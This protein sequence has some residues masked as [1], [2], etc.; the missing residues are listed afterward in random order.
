MKLGTLGSHFLI[1]LRLTQWGLETHFL[2]SYCG[3]GAQWCWKFL[4]EA[5]GWC[6][7]HLC[8][9]P[10]STAPLLLLCRIY[11]K[12]FLKNRH[13]KSSFPREFLNTGE[14]GSR[15]LTHFIQCPPKNVQFAANPAKGKI[16]LLSRV[17][18]SVIR[19]FQ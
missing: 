9:A 8:E 14:A 4:W 2:C 7:R 1:S 10:Q 6:W 12:K 18:Q 11:Q 17:A 15:G 13:T 16:P 19:N 5:A 3:S